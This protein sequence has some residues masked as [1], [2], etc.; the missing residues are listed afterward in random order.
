MEKKMSRTIR[1]RKKFTKYSEVEYINKDIDR[2]KR[3]SKRVYT[4]TA[5]QKAA[6]A[7]AVEE[8]EQQWFLYMKGQLCFR[9]QRPYKSDYT[10]SQRFLIDIDYEEVVK[11]SKRQYNRYHRD[12]VYSD[13]M[14]AAY[15][16]ICKKDR[17]NKTRK[18]INNIKYDKK[19]VDNICFPDDKDGKRFIWSIW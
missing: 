9:P 10:T 5:R 11:E 1:N 8:Y 14:K 17:R 16:Y 18:L 7:Q 15:K 13:S 4:Q 6:Y 12:G 19:D 3:K 2:E